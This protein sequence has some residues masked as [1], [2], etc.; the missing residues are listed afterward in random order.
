M[1]DQ[2]KRIALAHIELGEAILASIEGNAAT[3]APAPAPQPQAAPA[4]A[5]SVGVCPVHGIP[6]T[7]TKGDGSPAKRAYCKTKTNDEWCDAKGPWLQ[8]R[9]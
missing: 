9:S 1:S 3:V 4:P 2:L 6:W 8:P 5:A 7:T